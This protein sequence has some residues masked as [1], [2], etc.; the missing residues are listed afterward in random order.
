MLI[1][2]YAKLIVKLV[3]LIIEEI[4]ATNFL[5]PIAYNMLFLYF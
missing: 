3:K 2:L 5:T 4:P 1:Q